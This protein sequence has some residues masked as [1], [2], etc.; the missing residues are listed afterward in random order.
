MCAR[1]GTVPEIVSLP[2]LLVRMNQYLVVVCIQ[3]NIHFRS[4]IFYHFPLCLL[5]ILQALSNL[6]C[7]VQSFLCVVQSLVLFN[8][9]YLAP[10][11]ID[12]IY[13]VSD[14]RKLRL[15]H[16]VLHILPT[17][18]HILYIFIF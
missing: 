18:I 15:H 9:F 14:H 7:L 3:Q 11:K 10:T 8:L 6:L 13:I 12:Y 16:T 1:C 17:N 4:Y 2:G 5:P